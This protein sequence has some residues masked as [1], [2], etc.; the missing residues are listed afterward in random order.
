LIYVI[1]KI[2]ILNV[3]NILNILNLL[4][5]ILVLFFNKLNNK[6]IFN[7]MKSL[8]INSIIPLLTLLASTLTITSKNPVLSV[9]FL[10]I[11]FVLAA[12]YIM[13]LNINFIGISYIIVYV[14]AIAVLFLFIIMMI[15]IKLS[16]II[17]YGNQYTKTLP[18]GLIIISLILYYLFLIIP[19]LFDNL[20]YGD[21]IY[22]LFNLFNINNDY[23]FISN[24]T[25]ILSI[26]TIFKEISQ[27]DNVGFSLY[28]YG[29]IFLI[30]LSIIL[31]LGMISAI[32]IS[33][34][35]KNL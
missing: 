16:D 34:S 27:I 17:E 20:F 25:E 22:S 2:N 29:S 8:I 35:K 18:L 31:L 14:G 26:E 33:S 5:L 3:L 1:K 30:I 28:A 24:K 19:Y 12:C 10:I 23:N 7:K 13:L 21:Y 6:N 11:T 9:T 15:N 32:I 4:Y